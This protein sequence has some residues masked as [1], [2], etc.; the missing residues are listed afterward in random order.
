M[1][2]VQNLWNT[3]M[4]KELELGS[5]YFHQILPPNN[6][7]SIQIVILFYW[8]KS[9]NNTQSGIGKEGLS[10]RVEGKLSAGLPSL[11]LFKNKKNYVYYI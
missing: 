3:P 5:L 1:I 8:F 2:F 6:T 9:N 4:P 10:R 7:F 11:L